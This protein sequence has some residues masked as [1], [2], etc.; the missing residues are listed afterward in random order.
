MSRRPRWPV[1][2][3]LALLIAAALACSVEYSTAHLENAGTYKGAGRET[4]TRAFKP[5]DTIY[6]VVD[7]KDTGDTAL[8]V[9]LVVEQIVTREGGAAER[10]NIH[11]E[12]DPHTSGTLVFSLAPPDQRWD[13][14]KYEIKLY[15]DGDKKVTLEF[16]I[17]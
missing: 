1:W 5:G 15:L 16:T 13:R 17:K 8:E 2:I 7:L 11:R 12:E 6:C 9:R 14:G 10:I 4:K 3:G